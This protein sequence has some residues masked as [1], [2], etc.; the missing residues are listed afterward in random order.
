MSPRQCRVTCSC[1]TVEYEP[2][3]C[4]TSASKLPSKRYLRSAFVLECD[5]ARYPLQSA[6]CSSQHAEAVP[7]CPRS[8]HASCAEPSADL[9]AALRAAGASR[10]SCCLRFDKKG[11]VCS[12][13]RYICSHY[14]ELLGRHWTVPALLSKRGRANPETGRHS[15]ARRLSGEGMWW[16]LSVTYPPTCD[17]EGRQELIATN[18]CVVVLSGS[19][20][21]F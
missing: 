3:F 5:K 16:T 19:I 8:R 17:L 18:F 6:H 12:S 21:A 9:A 11:E 2:L 13:P 1:S 10:Q 7:R 4:A 14:Q 20:E 15:T